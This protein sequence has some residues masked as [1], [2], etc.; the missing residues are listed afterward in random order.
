MKERFGSFGVNFEAQGKLRFPPLSSFGLLKFV[1]DSD[2]EHEPNIY[3]TV[4]QKG[5]I[6]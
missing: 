1:Q 2:Q 5:M 4:K 3:K 6:T